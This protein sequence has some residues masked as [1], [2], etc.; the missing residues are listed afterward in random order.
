MVRLNDTNIQSNATRN[1]ILNELSNRG[2]IKQYIYNLTGDKY[3]QDE[4]LQELFLTL[5]ELD[6]KKLVTIYKGGRLNGY[7]ATTLN[8]MLKQQTSAFYKK[9]KSF[10]GYVQDDGLIELV[11]QDM[12]FTTVSKHEYLTCLEEAI[13]NLPY[14]EKRM[15]KDYIKLNFSIKKVSEK[16]KLTRDHISEAINRTKK[17]LRDEVSKQITKIEENRI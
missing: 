5:C 15:L 11:L 16:Y 1:T 3:Y 12:D 8:K 2:D 6:A 9:I 4:L 13:N 17:M 14:Y 10:K 7:I